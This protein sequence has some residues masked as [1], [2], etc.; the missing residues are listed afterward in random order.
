MS[1]KIILAFV[2]IL[3]H[4]IASIIVQLG[5]FINTVFSHDYTVK[6]I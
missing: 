5:L 2:V 1:K 6:R 3:I 4:F